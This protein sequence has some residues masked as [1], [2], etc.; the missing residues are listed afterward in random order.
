MAVSGASDQV[1]VR[2]VPKH[3]VGYLKDF[4]FDE[5]QAR[6]PVKSLSG[7]EKARLLLARIMA[8]ESNLL[9]LDEPTNDLDVETLDL[10]QDILGDYA[11]TVL[12]VSH[13]RDFL[14]RVATT[15]VAMEGDGEASIYAGGWTD[16]QSQR[17]DRVAESSQ[18]K[19]KSNNSKTTLNATSDAP[20]SKIS[21]TETHRLGEL[22]GVIARLEAEIVKLEGLLSDPELFTREPLK[23][24][25]ATA[26]LVE[27]QTSLSDAEEERTAIE[28]KTDI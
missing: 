9:V 16:Y 18:K 27:G 10:M 28:V 5:R 2:G 21:Y 3:V 22:P 17:K 15:T 6:A 26:G 8:R 12:L 19:T 25:K 23:F 11:G 4:L 20:A 14:D 1:M 7:G 24:Q 13:D